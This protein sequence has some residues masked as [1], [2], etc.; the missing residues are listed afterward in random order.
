MGL[1]TDL[2]TRIKNVHWGGDQFLYCGDDGMWGSSDGE[3]WTRAAAQVP[4]SS[5]ASIDGV[6]I[7]CNPVAGPWRSA[8]GA[9]S[10]QGMS[11]PMFEDVA[12][13]RP[14]GTAPGGGP[15]Q[16]IFLAWCEDEEGEHY[17]VYASTNLGVSWS[18]V[19]SFE[20]VLNPDGSAFEQGFENITTLSGCGN[21]GFVGTQRNEGGGWLSSGNIYSTTDGTSF[22]GG[23]AFGPPTFSPPGPFAPR[24]GYSTGGVGFDGKR[25]LAVGLREHNHTFGARTDTLRY[26]ISG[27]GTFTEQEGTEFATESS[28]G[29][30]GTVLSGGLY[31]AGGEN[32][33]ATTFMA[34]DIA[35]G[36]GFTGARAKAQFILGGP[37]TELVSTE[38]PDTLTIF[39]GPVCK[40]KTGAFACVASGTGRAGGVYI[41]KPNESFR[42]THSGVGPA[43]VAL[44][45]VSFPL[46]TP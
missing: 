33:F 6:W 4:A 29:F 31:V 41:A 30:D 44:G 24:M 21:R 28:V 36:Q 15:K 38:H 46:G 10:W 19:H 12:A 35:S 9:Q 8:D 32:T 42:Q 43:A 23:V 34:I 27:D 14:G 22:S 37:A 13:F 2:L 39:V 5:L 18:K 16:G 26:I 40:K 45:R 25:Y 11:A 7:A 17:D 20:A 3:S 1:L